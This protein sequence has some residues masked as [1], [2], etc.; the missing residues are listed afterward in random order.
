V[1]WTITI[2][3][4]SASLIAWTWSATRADNENVIRGDQ[5]YGSVQA[6]R[7]SAQ[8]AIQSFED[9]VMAARNATVIEEFVPEGVA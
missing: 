1:N 9:D 5:A 6:A 7:T 4:T 2:K 8:S 3:P